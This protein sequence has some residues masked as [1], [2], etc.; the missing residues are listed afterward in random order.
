MQ[1]I[2]IIKNLIN[3]K[4]Y[5]GCS[6]NIKRRFMEHKSPKNVA[7]RTTNLAKAFRK[8]GINNFSFD[9]LEI[10]PN[11]E[12]LS[13]REMYWIALLNPEY[14]MNDGGEGNLGHTVSDETK[15]ILRQHGKSQWDNLSE[16]QKANRVKNNLKGPKVGHAVSDES[17]KKIRQKLLGTKLDEVTK[18]K[19]SHSNSLSMKGNKNGNKS[20]LCVDVNGLVVSTYDSILSASKVIGICASNITNVLKGKQITAGGYYWGLLC[21]VETNRDEC[22]DVS[23]SLSRIEVRGV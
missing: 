2:Y 10:V 4:I 19:I 22:T 17:R 20:V 6:N 8:Y 18:Q 3:G 11:I 7:N 1:G 21:S 5:I 14:N 12:K 15:D 13:T 9:T 16:N 23:T